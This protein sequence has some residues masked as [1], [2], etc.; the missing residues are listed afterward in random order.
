MIL[1]GVNRRTCGSIPTRLQASIVRGDEMISVILMFDDD[2]VMPLKFLRSWGTLPVSHSSDL[3]MNASMIRQL[4]GIDLLAYFA[5]SGKPRFP[6][7]HSSL[8]D[9][10]HRQRGDIRVV[11][12]HVSNC[13]FGD[14]SED[15]L[16]DLVLAF[17]V[18]FLECCDS[19]SRDESAYEIR[20]RLN[21]LEGRICTILNEKDNR[22]VCLRSKAETMASRF[23]YLREVTQSC[24][25]ESLCISVRSLKTVYN[26]RV[27]KR[28][29]PLESPSERLQRAIVSL[30][31][32]DF[33]VTSQHLSLRRLGITDVNAS[34]VWMQVPECVRNIVSLDL[35]NNQISL[36][37]IAVEFLNRSPLLHKIDLRGNRLSDPLEIIKIADFMCEDCPGPIP[38]V[39]VRDNLINIVSLSISLWL[40]MKNRVLLD[41]KKFRLALGRITI[42]TNKTCDQLLS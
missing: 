25:P 2:S 21:E 28:R 14:Q 33:P 35:S 37:S 12:Q 39:D 13:V 32:A 10:M 29:R 26:T 41:H 20:S 34:K 4:R 24:S 18:E 27:S 23:R 31:F 40:H 19:L 1:S 16:L 36:G 9:C 38:F 6:T 22:R 42:A 17:A 11:S 15:P 30:S 3:L 8:R 5:A 7:V